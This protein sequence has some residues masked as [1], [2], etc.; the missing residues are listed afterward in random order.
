V[1][2]KKIEGGEEILKIF[3]LSD[4]TYEKRKNQTKWELLKN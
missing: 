1:E 4:N 3:Q 2:K